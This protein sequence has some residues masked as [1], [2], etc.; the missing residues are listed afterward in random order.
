MHSMQWSLS[1]RLHRNECGA[2][3]LYFTSATLLRI[4]PIMQTS[5]IKDLSR[6][7]ML[8][9]RRRHW[10]YVP[11]SVLS[12]LSAPHLRFLIPKCLQTPNSVSSQFFIL[13]PLISI[14]RSLCHLQTLKRFHT[15]MLRRQL[16]TRGSSVLHFYMQGKA[17]FLS[18]RTRWKLHKAG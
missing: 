10:L 2:F 9:M 12:G 3:T 1:L 8:C 4:L 14:S 7:F 6:I 11:H 15:Q 16:L 18:S 17:R 13:K 5:R